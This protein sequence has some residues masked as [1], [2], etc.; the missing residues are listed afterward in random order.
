MKIDKVTYEVDL[1]DG[2]KHPIYVWEAPVRVWHWLMVVTM[3]TMIVTGYLIGRPLDANL[4]NTWATFQFADIRMIHFIAG[5]CFTG[6]FVYRIFW[7]FMG[8]RYAHQIFL[9]PFWSFKF[10]KGIWDQ[11]LYYLFIKKTSPEYAAHNPLAATA[12]F[13]FFVL[14]SFCIII[15][16][17]ALYGQ[18]YGAGS[19]WYA[20]GG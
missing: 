5:I 1:S 18:P 19:G 14:G 12:M 8:N 3:F 13:G 11:A 20:C 4:G 15:T 2:D 10:L 7:A 17:L 9:P 6:L 16:G